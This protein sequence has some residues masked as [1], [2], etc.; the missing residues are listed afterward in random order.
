MD[1]MESFV[2]D[3]AQFEWVADVARRGLSV[4]VGMDELLDNCSA[5][6]P[7]PVWRRLGSLDLEA[8]VLQIREWLEHRLTSEPPPSEVDGLYF[9]LGEYK[10][11]QRGVGT[12][13]RLDL[14]GG[15]GFDVQDADCQWAVE[16]TY[17][18]NSPPAESIVLESIY[19][20]VQA[21]GEQH[22]ELGEYVLGLG[23]GC[24]AIREVAHV[25][26]AT[27]TQQRAWRGLAVGFNCGDAL[28]LGRLGSAGWLD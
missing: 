11:H 24:L 6:L 18:S 19:R 16:P 20:E 5:R 13:C 14:V 7:D 21:A 3:L 12:I 25:L 28:V 26:R 22:A 10:D 2:S 9:G 4:R 8:D 15:I 17:V 27:V 1:Q 23:Y